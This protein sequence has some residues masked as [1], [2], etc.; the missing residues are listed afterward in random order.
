[1]ASSKPNATAALDS[2][3]RAKK[4]NDKEKVFLL[5]D[6]SLIVLNALCWPE[7]PQL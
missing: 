2:P 5:S 3:C 7:K 4:K 1:M 6:E